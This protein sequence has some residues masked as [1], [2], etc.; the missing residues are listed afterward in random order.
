MNPGIAGSGWKTGVRLS[1]C[2]SVLVISLVAVGLLGP[3]MAVDSHEETDRSEADIERMLASMDSPEFR[4]LIGDDGAGVS[5]LDGDRTSRYV[6]VFDDSGDRIDVS[7]SDTDTVPIELSTD[8]QTLETIGASA[9]PEIVSRIAIAEGAIDVSSSDF[10][11]SVLLGASSLVSDA[12]AVYRYVTRADA[13]HRLVE[14]SPSPDSAAT[15]TGHVIPVAGDDHHVVWVHRGDTQSVVAS[16]TVTVDQSI[17]DP[18]AEPVVVSYHD[19]DTGEFRH[20][21][22]GLTPALDR[23]SIV[24]YE[25]DEGTDE[26]E[27]VSA[28]DRAM[29]SGV[30]P[31]V[32]AVVR[33]GVLTL[34][35]TAI[36]VGIVAGTRHLRRA[37]REE[38]SDSETDPIQPS[39]LDVGDNSG[40]RSSGSGGDRGDHSDVGDRALTDSSRTVSPRDSPV[41]PGADVIGSVEPPPHPDVTPPTAVDTASTEEPDSTRLRSVPVPPSAGDDDCEDQREQF[42]A[43]LA[44]LEAAMADAAAAEAAAE[45]AADRAEAAAEDAQAAEDRYD[46]ASDELDSAQAARDDLQDQVDEAREAA[47]DAQ[48]ERER[49]EREHRRV[50][51]RITSLQRQLRQMDEEGASQYFKA[52]LRKQIHELKQER[53]DLSHAHRESIA[54]ANEAESELGDLEDALEEAEEALDAAQ[55]ACENADAEAEAKHQEA[56]EAE[57]DAQAAAEAAEAAAEKAEAL[58]GEAEAAAEEYGECIEAYLDALEAQAEEARERSERGAEAAE[59]E[60]E[61]AEEHAEE[62]DTEA[63]KAFP[64]GDPVSAAG[65]EYEKGKR[66]RDASESDAN[67]A[68]QSADEAGGTHEEAERMRELLEE[69]RDGLRERGLPG[70]D[71]IPSGDETEEKTREDA[72][73]AAE[74]AEAARRS[75][76]GASGVFSRCEEGETKPADEVYYE[77]HWE[78]HPSE[79]V[80]IEFTPRAWDGASDHTTQG[81]RARRAIEGM[82]VVFA[83]LRGDVESLLTRAIEN[84]VGDV[85][86]DTKKGLNEVIEFLVGESTDMPTIQ[87]RKGIPAEYYAALFSAAEELLGGA[88]S[89]RGQ[90]RELDQG[91]LEIKITML[92]T[93]RIYD[94]VW[95]C[96]HGRWVKEVGDLSEE[97]TWTQTRSVSRNVSENRIP[98]SVREVVARHRRAGVRGRSGTRP[99]D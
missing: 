53:R 87:G 66:N 1:L 59:N 47:R 88:E 46:Q 12:D 78:P 39:D 76:D 56:T 21:T 81:Q 73:R 42:A 7:E 74:A 14:I 97:K 45:A 86:E 62:G 70:A 49:R 68:E 43:M 13:D 51:D 91:E 30:S 48:E 25:G 3:A 50:R 8:G 38:S 35:V 94:V 67:G 44:D 60:K 65:E 98:E 26:L 15:L 89:I 37:R 58:L 75:A 55:E 36:P 77:Q 4:L 32:F 17:D 5:V 33:L 69:F 27:V 52:P 84:F 54:A 72:E 23:A 85:D 63:E 24:L 22:V 20:V 31:P 92:Y 71:D 29:S 34:V 41:A 83:L 96:K 93:E 18:D 79:P 57:A 2:V 16:E 99:K 64:D 10:R 82:S 6:A 9:E 61:R 80:V 90:L 11:S 28:F 19:P 40:S 95:V